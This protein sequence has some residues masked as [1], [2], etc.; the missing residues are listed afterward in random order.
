MI[1]ENDLPVPTGI[2][3]H[4][5]VQGPAQILSFFILDLLLRMPNYYLVILILLYSLQKLLAGDPM[6]SGVFG[7]GIYEQVT[8]QARGLKL[9]GELQ[10]DVLVQG[11]RELI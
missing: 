7:F 6:T 11:E 8:L 5:S 9:K 1:F 4:A 10:V 3:A 2:S